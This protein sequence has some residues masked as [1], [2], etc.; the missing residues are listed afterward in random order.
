MIFD[1]HMHTEFSSDSTMKIED[2]IKTSKK[3]DLGIILTEHLDLIYPDETE[4]KLDIPKYLSTYDKYK[5]DSL[6]LGIELGLSTTIISENSKIASNYPFDFI[7]GSM[8]AVNDEDIY[9]SYCKQALTKKDYYS[10]YL[11]NT[12]E[13]IKSFNNFD[14]LG[15]IDYPCRYCNYEDNELYYSDHSDLFNELFKTLL[16]NNIVM[17]LNVRRIANKNSYLALLDI[18]KGYKA[19]GGKYIT[20]GSDAHSFEHIGYKFKEALNFL[21]QCGLT[22]IYFKNRKPEL[23]K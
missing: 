1:S 8:H 13:N 21:E 4:F 16:A 11:Q 2:A 19:L 18:Y 23:F 3:L 15:H 14:A 22:G 20:L 7:I 17:E 9:L 6:L 12:I 10:I 5:S